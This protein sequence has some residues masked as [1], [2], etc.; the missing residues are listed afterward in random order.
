MAAWTG[1]YAHADGDNEPT[2]K[3]SSFRHSAMVSSA[4]PL[5]SPSSGLGSYHI[6]DVQDAARLESHFM[7]DHND[8]R[9]RQPPAPKGER[10]LPIGSGLSASFEARV[11]G[12]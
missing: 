7:N 1:P 3:L 10:V 9:L 11:D 6:S 4:Y 2:L 12:R 8:I 5:P